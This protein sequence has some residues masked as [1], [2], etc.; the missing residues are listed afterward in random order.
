MATARSCV[1]DSGGLAMA[2]RTC[3]TL[4]NTLVRIAGEGPVA[5]ALLMMARLFRSGTN[6]NP[7]GQVF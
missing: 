1:Q 7:P 3:R 4:C 2:Q 5:R 6:T